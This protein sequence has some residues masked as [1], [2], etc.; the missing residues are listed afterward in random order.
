MFDSLSDKLVS[1]FDKIR[2][3]GSLSESDIASAMKE[4]RLALI[5]ADVALDV[6]K[7]FIDDI[8]LE[9]KGQQITKSIK[10]D[11]MVFKIVQDK[12]TDL[13]GGKNAEN[14]IKLSSPPSSIMLVGLQG[15]GKTT[16]AAKM[17]LMLKGSGKKV[18]L[19][20]LDVQRPA[21]M[22]QL[23][24]LGDQTNIDV[25]PIEKS[26]GPVEITKRSQQ[27]AKLS[28]YDVVIL[29]T[30]G[31]TSVDDELMD[32]LSEVY[33]TSNPS[34]VFLV[35]DA[36][37]GQEAANVARSFKEKSNVTSIILTRVD[38]DARGGAALSMSNITNCPIKFMGTG[39]KLEAFETFKADRIASRIL[40]MGDVVSLVEKAQSEVKEEE[41]KDLAKKISKGTFDFNDFRKQ[42]NQMKKMGGMQG[43]LSLLPGA[44]KIK[45]QMAVGGLDDKILV[46]MDSMISSM[47]SKERVNP[48]LLNGSRKRRIAEG[49][50]N[51]VQDLNRLLKQFKQM[52]LM[53]KKM[54]KKGGNMD[55]SDA[56]NMQG[57]DMPNGLPKGFNPGSFPFR[58]R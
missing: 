56:M 51:S 30:A 45:K 38:G 19:A 16:S 18:L 24:I 44:Q 49:S 33:K 25:L 27:L 54:G 47:T 50:G 22:E 1:A 29:D 58:R 23:Q 9:A 2:G 12:L 7:K 4:V 13:L 41:A 8:T 34:E 5:D 43:I 46:R 48:K 40:G 10:P 15:S 53:M 28:G 55:I 35:A 57:M 11:Q 52:T 3:K 6:V 37:T 42:L 17:G 39:E 14:T 31:R 32:E 26:Q 21:A 20:S 36:M